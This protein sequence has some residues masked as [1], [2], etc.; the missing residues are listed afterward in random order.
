MRCDERKLSYFSRRLTPLAWKFDSVASL[1]VT[2]MRQAQELGM[3]RCQPVH[4]RLMRFH[5]RTSQVPLAAPY[6]GIE[7]AG[8]VGTILTKSWLMVEIYRYRTEF[9]GRATRE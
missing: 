8:K 7:D 1:N 9:H 5:D 2:S 3:I 4:T 6:E